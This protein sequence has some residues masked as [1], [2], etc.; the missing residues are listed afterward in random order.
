MDDNK[1][2]L[3]SSC[4]T[5]NGTFWVGDFPYNTWDAPDYQHYQQMFVPIIQEYYPRC[6][7][8]WDSPINKE[9]K[10]FK[11][12]QKLMDMEIIQVRTVK[13]FIEAVNAVAEVI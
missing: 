1:I 7:L 12:V 5:K 13:Q 2:T 11:I 10:A 4:G 8:L 9:N 6:I 3:S